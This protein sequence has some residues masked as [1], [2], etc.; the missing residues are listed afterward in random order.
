MRV[1][2][3]TAREGIH[4]SDPDFECLRPETRNDFRN[5]RTS[6]KDVLGYSPGGDGFNTS[7]TAR[8]KNE[9]KT[10]VVS[11]G[12]EI[13]ETKVMAPKICPVFESQ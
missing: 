11:F 2:T 12:Q 1:C 4:Q 5:V 3:L 8:E 10:K 7:G 9:A 6:K 13:T